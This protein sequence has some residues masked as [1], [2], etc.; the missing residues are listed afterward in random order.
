LYK[1]PD[2]AQLDAGLAADL[3]D[4]EQRITAIRRKVNLVRPSD[5]APDLAAALR[6]L[7]RARVK[8]SNEQA[9]F[10][11]QQKEDDFQEALRLS[12]GLVVDVVAS[13]DTVIPGQEFNLTV[14]AVNGGPFNFAGIRATTDLPAGWTITVDASTGSLASGQRLE[15]KYKVKAGPA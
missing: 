13:D 14:S 8:T 11:L 6:I 1:L 7:Q 3:N 2:L 12:S 5:I 4:V 15:Q 10:L 9:R